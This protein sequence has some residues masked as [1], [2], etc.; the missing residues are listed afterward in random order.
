MKAFC[1]AEQCW[2]NWLYLIIV[3]A[4]DVK[5]GFDLV[6]RVLWICS[7]LSL[8]QHT[9]PGCWS[10]HLI[11]PYFFL[12]WARMTAHFICLEQTQKLDFLRA[13]F[14]SS[15]W[16]WRL[17]YEEMLIISSCSVGMWGWVQAEVLWTFTITGAWS[18]A[19]DLRLCLVPEF[20]HL[21]HKVENPDPELEAVLHM[22]LSSLCCVSNLCKH[23]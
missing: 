17:M 6:A 14:S 11:T 3:E 12:L 13:L 1:Q 18:Q 10:F 23:E 16:G 21:R 20:E 5:Q 8:V 9:Q 15:P 7:A 2:V 22:C 19:W 4:P